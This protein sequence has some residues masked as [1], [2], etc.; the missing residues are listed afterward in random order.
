MQNRRLAADPA[1]YS[2]LLN[3][4]AKVESKGNYNAYFSNARNSSIDFTKMSVR[5]VRQWQEDFIREGNV[6]SAV[7]KYQII[8]TTL[9]GLVKEL[10]VDTNMPFDQ[11]MQDRMAIALIERR[12]AEAYVN[13]EL[14]KEEF[15]AN[16]AKEWASLPKVIGEN[17]N[18]SYYASD[19]LNKSLVR[20]DEVLKAIEPISPN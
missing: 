17:P 8:S 6:S 20:I 16:L 15:A 19:G 4:I 10:G 5:E 18:Q 9:D 2:Q 3:L 12:G 1:T 7:G 11:S 13:N 14:T